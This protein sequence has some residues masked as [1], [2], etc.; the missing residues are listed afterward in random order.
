MDAMNVAMLT[1]TA[2]VVG[3]L[4]PVMIQLYITLRQVR[5]DLSETR[6]RLD[7]LLDKLNRTASMTSALTA[8][9]VAGV[10]AFRDQ[11]GQPGAE[12]PEEEDQR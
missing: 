8:A 2:L 6:A 3:M 5:T 10:R 1:L 4:V 11:T 12:S 7:P 9:V